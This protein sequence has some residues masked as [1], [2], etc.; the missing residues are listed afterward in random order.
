MLNVGILEGMMRDKVFFLVLLFTVV[1]GLFQL[2]EVFG[3]EQTDILRLEKEWEYI[4]IDIEEDSGIPES[5]WKHTENVKELEEERNDREILYLRHPITTDGW[6]DPAIFI[7]FMYGSFDIYQ[8]DKHLYRYGAI[9]AEKRVTYQGYNKR[10]VI[11][12]EEEE[13]PSMLIIRSYSNGNLIGVAGAVSIGSHSAYLTQMIKDDYDKIVL[14]AI[15]LFIAIV[16]LITFFIKR[17]KM[18]YF[19]FAAMAFCS[20]LYS[21]SLTGSKQFLF[22][23]PYMWVYLFQLAVFFRSVFDLMLVDSLFGPGYKKLIR[24]LWQIHLLL[25]SIAFVLSMINPDHFTWTKGIFEK[26]SA[27]EVL[28]VLG[29][30][31]IVFFRNMEAKIFT[32]GYLAMAGF[33]VRDLLVFTGVIY[34]DQF[35]LVGH[36]GQFILLL[37]VGII[38]MIKAKKD[39]MYGTYLR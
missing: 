35:Y 22:D 11:E 19:I 18:I 7:S 38:L 2:N 30:A 5:G 15:Q 32:I 16:A 1:S 21:I 14:G 29:I 37:A 4:W 10:H 28:I 6:K 25:A 23:Y 33:M 24:R 13:Q 39:N 27:I 17:L 34:L 3:Q 31:A 8:G 20:A 9:P 12:L 36:V 26:L